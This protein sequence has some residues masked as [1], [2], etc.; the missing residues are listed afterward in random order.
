MNYKNAIEILK[1]YNV[2]FLETLISMDD[3][4][5]R[6]KCRGVLLLIASIS[7]FTFA[8]VEYVLADM[9]VPTG[10]EVSVRF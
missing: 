9:L 1:K 6:M 7:L 10:N 3:D 8:V 2:Y 5:L 4:A